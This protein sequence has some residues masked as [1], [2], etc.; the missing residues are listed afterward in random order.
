MYYKN[1]EIVYS[2]NWHTS[3]SKTMLQWWQESIPCTHTAKCSLKTKRNTGLKQNSV[4][5]QHIVVCH[6][7]LKNSHS[8][9]LKCMTPTFR[10]WKFH[11]IS[12]KPLQL[13]M[14]AIL[15]NLATVIIY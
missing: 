7:F 11:H 13:H 1:K 6:M 8:K 12:T 14:N 10:V 3:A 9:V 4:M 15:T 2:R 5:V